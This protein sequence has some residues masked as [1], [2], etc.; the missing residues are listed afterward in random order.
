[1][2]TAGFGLSGLPPGKAEAYSHPRALAE[3]N[4]GA[5]CLGTAARTS[6]PFDFLIGHN[7]HTARR[8]T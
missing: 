6:P 5:F 1:M 8:V 3:A 2:L 7:Y 4:T